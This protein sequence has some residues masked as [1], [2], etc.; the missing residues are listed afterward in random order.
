[1]TEQEYQ[2]WEQ[3]TLAYMPEFIPQDQ[4]HMDYESIDVV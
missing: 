3:E 1:M 2:E 4:E